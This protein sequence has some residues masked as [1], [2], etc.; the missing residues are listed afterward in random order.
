MTRSATENKGI[1]NWIDRI[2]G[3]KVI[4]MILILL[5]LYST[6]TIF[7]STSQLAT[8][9][10]SRLD[11]FLEQI[12]T[13]GIGM[14][15][16]FFCYFCL[17]IGWIRVLSQLGFF[18][19]AVLLMMLLFRIGTVELN[20]AVRIIMIGK[21]QLN[22]YEFVKIFMIVYLAWAIHA[23]K[24][25]SFWIADQLAARSRHLAFLARA[26]WKRIIYIYIPIIFVTLCIMEGGFSSAMFIGTIM[27]ATILIGGVP[28]KDIAMLV[29]AGIIAIGGSYMLYK[30][31]GEKIMA[32]RWTTVESRI[33]RLFNPQPAD[34]LVEGTKEWR[35]HIDDIRQPEGAKIAIK[36]GGMFGKGPGKSTQKY[37]VAL[38]F[39]DY[40]FSFII[41]EYG[42]IFGAIPLI[43]LYISLL[44][45][46][47]LIVRYCDNEY[48]KT[49][50]A[51]LTLVIAAQAMMHMFI[52]VG[53]GPLTGQ[54][55]PMISH[56]N[57]SFIA[58]SI[59]FGILLSISKMAKK[60]IDQAT[61]EAE[62][63]IAESCPAETSASED[64]TEP[65]ESGQQTV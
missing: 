26:G 57:S 4:W 41:E 28:V 61:R 18:V 64:G 5:I 63:L 46:G 14:A 59:A 48:A 33:G 55:L 12:I 56:G 8:L 51:G 47:S 7:S 43:V 30:V 62:S 29:A 42:L 19:S 54:T 34:E 58:F 31:S 23:Y 32:G 52:N 16:V 50:I 38:I 1:W 6:V 21:L 39:S 44:A 60:K 53:L 15:I 11:I 45:R 20:N 25:G 3:D 17:R 49:V 10:T 27:I 13:V 40:M 24:S 2:Q 22:V 35:E 9:E 36:E 65:A 37:S